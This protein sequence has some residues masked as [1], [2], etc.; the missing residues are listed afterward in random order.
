MRRPLQKPA[1]L[2]LMR[3]LAGAGIGMIVV[4]SLVP[5]RYRLST[6]LASELEHFVAYCVTA[7][8]S[9]LAFRSKR[10]MFTCI[11]VGAAFL[12]EAAQ[13]IIPSRSARVMDAVVSAAGAVFGSTLTVLASR[14]ARRT[15]CVAARSPLELDAEK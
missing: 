7:A 10:V 6:E 9:V 11:L 13:I 2:S 14:L 3:V 4:L 1:Y 5:G 8:L 12:F 15:G